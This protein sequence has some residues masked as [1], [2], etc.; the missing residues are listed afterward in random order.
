MEDLLILG[1]FALLCL[2]A[3]YGVYR[4]V[5]RSIAK[6]KEA[7]RLR[8]EAIEESKARAREARAKLR[9]GANKA[10]AAMAVQNTPPKQRTFV[11]REEPAPSYT[12]SPTHSIQ[13]SRSILDD[14][15]DI[16]MIANTIH[17][18]NDNQRSEPERVERSAGVTKS[19]SSW[20][21]DDSDSRKSV[22]DTFGSSSSSYSS[23]SSDSSWSSSSSSDSFSSSA[24]SDW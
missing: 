20:G 10:R 18:W 1:G 5:S 17:H 15:A 23:S 16:A 12:L 2:G 14:A 4:V 24:S 11:K 8:L 19:E 9:E 22:R 7:D 3:I 13:S 6:S 21:F